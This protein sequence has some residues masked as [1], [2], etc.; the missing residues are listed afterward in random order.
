MS[1]SRERLERDLVVLQEM[2][3]EMDDYL[4]S[5]VLFWLMMKGGM[6]K[7]TLGGYLV[8]QHRLLSLLDQL[9]QEM[10][11]ALNAA[12]FQFSQVLT[13]RVV[14]LEQKAHVE[15]EARI[16]QWGEYLKDL[17]WDR[18]AAVASYGAAVETRA[19]LT[20]LVEKLQTPPYQLDPAI[21]PKV[22]L[23]D[24]NLRQHWQPGPFVWPEEWES[25]YPIDD[26]WWLYGG[27]VPRRR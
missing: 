8:R 17:S 11:D 23:L 19:I 16:R 24:G 26:Y 6:P 21:P 22:A 15:L 12:V 9:D 20:A 5:D 18:S 25:A 13:E 1:Q 14:R 2:A 4:T 10:Q 27:P 7:L 3:G